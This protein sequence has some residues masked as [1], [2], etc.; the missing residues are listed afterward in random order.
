[1]ER[2]VIFVD[3]ALAQIAA[4]GATVAIVVG[5]IRTVAVRIGSA[6]ALLSWG[7]RSCLCTDAPRPHSARSFY[8]DCLLGGL[9]HGHPFDEQGHRRDRAPQGHARRKYFAVSWPK[10]RK[11]AIL[12]ALVGIFHY[13]FR[14]KFLLISMKPRKSGTAWALAC[15]SGLLILRIVRFV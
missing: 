1:V 14:K 10:F 4:L 9:C 3:L 8:R 13:V 5:R 7:P 12:Y 6:W 2:G 15:A 11:T